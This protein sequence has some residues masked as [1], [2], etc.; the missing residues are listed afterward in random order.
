MEYIIKAMKLTESCMLTLRVFTS[1]I[2]LKRMNVKTVLKHTYSYLQN[3][4][5]T[6]FTP[7]VGDSAILCSTH[8]YSLPNGEKTAKGE[9]GIT[10]QFGMPVII[11]AL[12][13]GW[14]R[15]NS[16]FNAPIGYIPIQNIEIIK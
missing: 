3:A 12:T 8:I 7:Q 4:T 14:C 11:S 5:R 6:N 1:S 13:N 16:I 2:F 15:V 10:V 9:D